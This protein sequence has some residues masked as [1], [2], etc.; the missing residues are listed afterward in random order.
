MAEMAYDQL[1][2]AP[3]EELVGCRIAAIADKLSIRDKHV[4]SG[5]TLERA[6]CR[7][8]C[9]D[10]ESPCP[11]AADDAR[12]RCAGQ[13]GAGGRYAHHMFAVYRPPW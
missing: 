6:S 4:V 2:V 7:R 11:D 1:G 8:R 12:W 9:G 13:E 10:I 3:N 5:Q